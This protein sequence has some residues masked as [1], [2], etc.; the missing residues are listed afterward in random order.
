MGRME[1]MQRVQPQAE[2]LKLQEQDIITVKV[3][4]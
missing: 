2:A 4:V 1:G 3:R